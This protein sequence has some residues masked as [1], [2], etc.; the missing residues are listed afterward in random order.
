MLCSVLISGFVFDIVQ[1]PNGG[2]ASRC[3]VSA[4]HPLAP[5]ARGPLPF[6]H[7]FFLKMFNSY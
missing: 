2:G 3:V 6:A 5:L 7:K 1:I 4:L